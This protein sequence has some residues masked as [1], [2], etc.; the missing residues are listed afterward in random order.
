MEQVIHTSSQTLRDMHMF[1]L[2]T[3]YRIDI[4]ENII[5]QQILVWAHSLGHLGIM[6]LQ[7][8]TNIG[9]LLDR[10]TTSNATVWV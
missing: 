3:Q 7:L 5:V 10:G 9:L 1:V 2:Y 6:Q 8:G 4:L